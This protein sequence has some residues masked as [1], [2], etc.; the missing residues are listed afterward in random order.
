MKWLALA[1]GGVLACQLVALLAI[2]AGHPDA[3]VVTVV[4]TLQPLIVFLVIPVAMTVAILRHQLFD[5]D[6][7]I[8]RALRYALLSA[9]ITAVYAGIVLGLG[10]VIGHRSGPV[11]TIG[12]RWPSRCCSSRC[13]SGPGSWPTG[14]S[15]GCGPRPTRC[16]PTSRRTWRP[17]ST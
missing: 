10:T 1:I 15:T 12:P 16:C 8:S 11:L 5:I 13:A 17:S 6:L 14:W 3:T 4:Y 2:A 9:A 7:I